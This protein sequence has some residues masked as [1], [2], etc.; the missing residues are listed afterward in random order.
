MATIP[1][2]K[3]YK[4]TLYLHSTVRI[5]ES[6]W[7]ETRLHGYCTFLVGWKVTR[8]DK[9]GIWEKVGC[10]DKHSLLRNLLW[11]KLVCVLQLNNRLFE[12]LAMDVYD[13]VDR[14]ENDAGGPHS[15]SVLLHWCIFWASCL[16]VCM[17][18]WIGC[19]CVTRLNAQ[20]TDKHT[21][22]FGFVLFF[23]VWLTTQ[24]HSTLV[25]ERSAVPFL[26]V[27]P[28]YSATRNQVTQNKDAQIRPDPFCGK[29]HW[30]LD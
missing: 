27:N 15:S 10:C 23:P 4:Y 11:I 20:M 16:S 29:C 21:L 5:C 30:V 2:E 8:K 28:E 1:N 17:C 18:R 3:I 25:T 7:V 6:C 12:E 13:E 26:P 22:I 19:L 24:N 9:R 14:R